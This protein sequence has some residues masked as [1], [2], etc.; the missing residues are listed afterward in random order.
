M[1]GN[2][3]LGI[4]HSSTGGGASI[5]TMMTMTTTKSKVAGRSR[6]LER[7][8]PEGQVAAQGGEA[9]DEEHP[10]D[11]FWA[12]ANAIAPSSPPSFES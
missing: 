12:H 9:G 6:G 7:R 1:A 5:A 11:G 3:D 2:I 8:R 10:Y 4:E